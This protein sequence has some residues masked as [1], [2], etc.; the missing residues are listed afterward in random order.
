MNAGYPGISML[1]IIRNVPWA[2]DQHFRL[3]SAR[4]FE[5][6]SLRFLHLSVIWPAL[7]LL[8]LFLALIQSV[9][10]QFFSVLP[11]SLSVINVVVFSYQADINQSCFKTYKS[12]QNTTLGNMIYLTALLSNCSF[13][14]GSHFFGFSLHVLRRVDIKREI[15]HLISQFVWPFAWEIQQGVTVF[16]RNIK[17]NEFSKKHHTV[18]IHNISREVCVCV[19]VYRY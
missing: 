15:N 18:C 13:S 11:C 19:C 10:G 7:P 2:A 9:F 17:L 12:C 5:V 16:C 8:F 14:Y 3:I 1:I 4:T 6:D